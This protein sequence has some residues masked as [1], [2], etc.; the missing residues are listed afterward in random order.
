[1]NTLECIEHRKSVRNYLQKVIPDDVIE[2]IINM[3][4]K[5]PSGKN[6]QPWR[7][8]VVHK[9]KKLLQELAR[10]TDYYRSVYYA[11]CIIFVFLDKLNSYHYIK[12]V[13]GIGACIENM[14][15][16]ADELGVGACWNGDILRNAANVKQKL[17]IDLRYDLMAAI[18]LGYPSVDHT[19]STGR[20]SLN[21][22]LLGNE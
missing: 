20:K 5:A 1:M 17:H 7:F 18:V 14:L 22:V 16:A 2:K 9:N 11:D 6:G 21:E 10:E 15:L 4:C 3:G 13:Q 12:D 19:Y 8:Y